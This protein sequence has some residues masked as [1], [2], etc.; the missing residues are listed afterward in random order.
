[1]TRNEE[2][3]TVTDENEEKLRSLVEKAK[4]FSSGIIRLLQKNLKRE[5]MLE[6]LDTEFLRMALLRDVSAPL[7]I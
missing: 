2:L 1:M 7:W 4:S 3:L 5:N 6:L